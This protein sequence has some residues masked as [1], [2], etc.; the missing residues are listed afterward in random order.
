MTSKFNTNEYYAYLVTGE[1]VCDCPVVSAA[2]QVQSQF[3][4]YLKFSPDG[5]RVASA[6]AISDLELFTFDACTG[7]LAYSAA[8]PR[9]TDSSGGLSHLYGVCFSTDGSKLYASTGWFGL[10]G[11]AKL[12]Q[13]DLNANDVPPEPGRTVR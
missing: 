3:Q 6:Q 9:W 8:I 12:Y 5:T 10:E 11:C 7:R 2:G 1:G 13:Y 4:G